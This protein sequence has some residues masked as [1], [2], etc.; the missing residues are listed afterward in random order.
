[1]VQSF[2]HFATFATCVTKVSRDASWRLTAFDGRPSRETDW[3]RMEL[4]ICVASLK[5]YLSSPAS[6][7]SRIHA[8]RVQFNVEYVVSNCPRLQFEDVGF[9]RPSLFLVIL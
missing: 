1:M 2:A 5:Y 3:S 8:R 4:R 9:F 7:K 6:I